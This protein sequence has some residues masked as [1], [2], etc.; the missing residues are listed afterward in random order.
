MIEFLKAHYD[1]VLSCI[2]FI[3]TLVVFIIRKRPVTKVGLLSEI[4]EKVLERIPLLI[5][6]VEHPKD[7][8]AKKNLVIESSLEFI[9]QLVGH[10]LSDVERDYFVT[11]VSNSIES[12]LNTPE[13]KK[14]KL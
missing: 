2:L 8:D 5:S 7:G 10:T 14:Q 12:I 3:L 6:M 13:R 9:T 11:F 4:K 1:F